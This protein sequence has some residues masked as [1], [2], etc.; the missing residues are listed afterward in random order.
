MKKYQYKLGTIEEKESAFGG[1]AYLVNYRGE[2]RG[3]AVSMAKAK[4]I[5]DRC[6]KFG[7]RH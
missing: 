6:E 1:I 5:I 3:L 2:C 7:E 4:A